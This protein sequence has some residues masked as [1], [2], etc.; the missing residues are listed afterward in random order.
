MG[1]YWNPANTCY[2][3]SLER[4]AVNQ[5]LQTHG[6]SGTP[7]VKTPTGINYT[8]NVNTGR[9]SGGST[10]QRSQPVGGPDCEAKQ[11]LVQR[12]TSEGFRD[13][14]YRGTTQT[15]DGQTR[16]YIRGRARDGSHQS[17]FFVA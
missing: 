12:M 4:S 14:E 13:L 9:S 15:K 6:T 5:Y 2:Y 1:V 11:S 8:V 16:H 17:R 7:T 10:G 3:R